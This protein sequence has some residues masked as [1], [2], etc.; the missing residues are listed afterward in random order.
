MGYFM[1]LKMVAPFSMQEKNGGFVFV[2]LFLYKHE[3][4]F[5]FIIKTWNYSFFFIIHHIL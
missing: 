5:K 3:I 1:G 4:V 2:V